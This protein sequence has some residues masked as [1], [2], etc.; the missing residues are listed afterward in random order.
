MLHDLADILVRYRQGLLQGTL[1][2]LELAVIAWCVGLTVGTVLGAL[3]ARLKGV[4]EL[5]VRVLTFAV[6]SIPILALLFWAH[7]PLQALL[8]VVIDP[9]MTAAVLLSV[10]NTLGVSA[11]VHNGVANFPQEYLVA[12]R[13]CGIRPRRAFWR[14]EFPLI[15]RQVLPALLQ[16]QVTILHATLFAS[17]ISVNELFRVA[18]RINALEYRPIPIYTALAVFFLLICAPINLLAAALGKR[19]SRSLSEG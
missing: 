19:Y 9:F 3:T 15:L 2:T 7:Y 18:Q 5:G 6:M 1:I 8:G 16:L 17:L 11:I 10:L 12:A 14:I 4:V 13:V